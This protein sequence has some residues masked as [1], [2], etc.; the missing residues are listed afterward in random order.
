MKNK[1]TTTIIIILLILLKIY[2]ISVQPIKYIPENK[3]DDALML[4]QANS[5][6]QGKWLGEYNSLTLVKGPI[7]PIF[8]AI[9]NKLHIPFLI[10]QELLYDVSCLF[11]IYTFSK[12]IKNK[13]ILYIIFAILLFNP[14]TFS[15]EICRVY[16]DGIYTSLTMLLIGFSYSIFLITGELESL[17]QSLFEKDDDKADEEISKIDNKWKEVYDKLAYYIEHDELEK[18]ESNFTACKSL[19]KTREYEQSISE[20]EKTVYVLEHITDKYSFNLVNI[21]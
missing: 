16:R 10:G 15:T 8:I 6:L 14:V 13:K 18:V 3:Y 12:T 20:L 1:I 7:T 4:K 11:V 2:L 17:K 19:A 21:F 5:I 9:L